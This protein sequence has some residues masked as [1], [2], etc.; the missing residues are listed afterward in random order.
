MNINISKINY[1]GGGSSGGGGASGGEFTFDLASIGWDDN[2]MNAYIKR[3]EEDIEYT[4][5]NPKTAYNASHFVFG[6][7]QFSTYETNKFSGAYKLTYIPYIDISNLTTLHNMFS[8]CYA[9]QM[10]NGIERWDTSNITSLENIFNECNSLEHIDISNWNISNVTAINN[11]FNGCKSI[12]STLNLSK[13]DTSKVIGM[14]NAFNGLYSISEI[15]LSG[16]DFSNVDCSV[17]LR[18]G[19]NAMFANL[20]SRPTINLSNCKMDKLSSMGNMFDS[21]S[22]NVIFDGV[23]L[24]KI[25]L[26]DWGL[27]KATL[28]LTTL[29]GVLNALP[30][31]TNDGVSY[32]C[33]LGAT[34]LNQLTDE[35]KLIATNKGWILS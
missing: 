28:S 12:S 1:A 14:R 35:Q 7:K 32:T 31:L 10:I 11:L 33:K 18:N 17:T 22:N 4:K 25:N 3:V 29:T 5:E 19:L 16:W 6:K 13:W 20:L 24:P 21:Y 2:D 9:L 27:N 30:D 8:Q 26:E 15:N 23:V 34:N